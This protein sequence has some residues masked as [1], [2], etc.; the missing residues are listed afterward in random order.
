MREDLE[1]S[2]SLTH[3]F[4]ANDHL[5][6]SLIKQLTQ[7]KQKIPSSVLRSYHTLHTAPIIPPTY[8]AK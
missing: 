3:H 2:L 7:K 1:C 8:P 4:V 6:S 5:V